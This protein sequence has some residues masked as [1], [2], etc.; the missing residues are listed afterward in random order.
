MKLAISISV[1]LVGF[2]IFY[3]LVIFIPQKSSQQL[4]QK[5]NT[6]TV[7]IINDASNQRA[8]ESCLDDVNNRFSSKEAVA[9]LKGVSATKV[10]VDFILTVLKE[11]KEECYKK[12]PQK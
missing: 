6:E 5:L 8:L 12:Y 11:A 1:L 4:E 7:K 2:S 9:A 10:N 3:Y